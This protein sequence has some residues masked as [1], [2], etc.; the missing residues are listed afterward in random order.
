MLWVT[1]RRALHPNTEPYRGDPTCSSGLQPRTYP[2]GRASP[3]RGDPYKAQGAQPCKGD[4]T[5]GKPQQIIQ[6]PTGATLDISPMPP[7]A[8]LW[9]AGR[10]AP[11]RPRLHKSHRGKGSSPSPC[12]SKRYLSGLG[13]A[14]VRLAR[15]A[16]TP[17]AGG[18]VAAGAFVL[19]L[20][21]RAAAA[22][23]TGIHPA[24]RHLVLRPR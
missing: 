24:A 12:E 22:L 17:L 1:P 11:L 19:A 16:A 8:P 18:L 5:L 13:R 14:D 2:N 9:L 21:A 7:P 3:Y 20:A 6:S 10:L 15:T 23:G 4:Q